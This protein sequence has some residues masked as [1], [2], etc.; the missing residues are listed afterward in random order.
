MIIFNNGKYLFCSDKVESRCYINS[1]IAF[2]Q[3]LLLGVAMTVVDG[4]SANYADGDVGCIVNSDQNQKFNT[5]V[6]VSIA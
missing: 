4:P 3:S 5:K 1:Y 6:N 2:L